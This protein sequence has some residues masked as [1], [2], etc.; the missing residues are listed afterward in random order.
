MLVIIILIISDESINAL[1][2]RSS[3]DLT[4]S[5]LMLNFSQYYRFEDFQNNC[6][7]Y[8]GKEE[9]LQKG[10]NTIWI[11]GYL[12]ILLLQHPSECRT[13][14]DLIKVEDS[15]KL[16]WKPDFNTFN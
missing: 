6:E 9:Q 1:M 15:N 12:N 4:A 3:I 7:E 14:S 13:V 16:R 8:D 10:S 11:Q 2:N 5:S